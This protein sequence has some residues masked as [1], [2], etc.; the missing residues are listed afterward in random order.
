MMGPRV[1]TPGRVP[2]P[3]L[4]VLQ[5]SRTDESIH[6]NWSGERAHG[7]KLQSPSCFGWSDPGGEPAR[8]T[9]FGALPLD[10]SLAISTTA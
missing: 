6:S 5:L 9:L 7:R 4:F 10:R 8:R 1:L 2:H 3:D